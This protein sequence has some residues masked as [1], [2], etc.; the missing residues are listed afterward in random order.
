M[1][2]I[3]VFGEHQRGAKYFEDVPFD[4]VYALVTTAMEDPTLESDENVGV[5]P[6]REAIEVQT[7]R[8][9]VMRTILAKTMI[10]RIAK[11]PGESTYIYFLLSRVV[12]N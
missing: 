4:N 6:A 1:V 7:L 10:T 5:E 11:L 12:L 2:N 9:M 3:G 8:R